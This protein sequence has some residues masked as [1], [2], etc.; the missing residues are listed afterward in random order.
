MKR[1]IWSIIPLAVMAA[2]C[3]SHHAKVQAP[4]ATADNFYPY[5]KPLSTPGSRF[6]SLP[7]VVKST[8]LSEAGTVEISDVSREISAGRVIYRISFQDAVDYPPIFIGSDGSVLNP[9][10][11]VA[12]AAPQG[13]TSIKTD[14][15]PLN[16]LRAI[17]ERAPETEVAGVRMEYWGDHTVYIVSFKKD[18]LYPKMYVVAD[19]TVLTMAPPVKP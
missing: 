15:L 2:G 9:D 5:H 11:T 17:R 1:F 4:P 16:V 10:L 12:I 18:L 6:G 14:D 3:A 8:V 19:G 7:D 13:P